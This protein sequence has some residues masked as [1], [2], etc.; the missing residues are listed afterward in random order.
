MKAVAYMTQLLGIEGGMIPPKKSTTDMSVGRMSDH[1]HRW[2][3][4][5]TITSGMRSRSCRKI[6][7]N[8]HL[9]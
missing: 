7:R 2:A 4:G 3:D 9:K 6:L 8:E 5:Q 1:K